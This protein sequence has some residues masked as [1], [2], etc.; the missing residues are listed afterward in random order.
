MTSKLDVIVIKLL[1]DFS[2]FRAQGGR[3]NG[4]RE[5]DFSDTELCQEILGN[6][7]LIKETESPIEPS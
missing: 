6:T 3:A 4:D 5:R 7:E 1:R 2:N